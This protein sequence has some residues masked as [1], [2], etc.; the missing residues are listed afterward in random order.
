MRKMTNF[1]EVDVTN[2]L[3]KSFDFITNGDQMYNAIVNKG[4]M[5]TFN[6]AVNMV[7]NIKTLS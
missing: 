7:G 1:F 2:F 5:G 4:I 3:S 6:G